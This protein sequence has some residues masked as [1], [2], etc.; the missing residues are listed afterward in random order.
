[1]STVFETCGESPCAIAARTICPP[2]C[3]GQKLG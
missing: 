3:L 2:P 1:V